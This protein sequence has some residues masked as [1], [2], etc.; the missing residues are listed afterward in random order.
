MQLNE[1]PNSTVEEKV[2][3]LPMFIAIKHSLTEIPESYTHDKINEM[4]NV[5]F[6]A[7][8]SEAIEERIKEAVASIK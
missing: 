1:I 5:E 4:S 3:F 2:K 8:L 6:L 7:A